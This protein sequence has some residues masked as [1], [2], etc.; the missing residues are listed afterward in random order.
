[1]ISISHTWNDCYLSH[2]YAHAH[3]QGSLS[4]LTN[5][6]GDFKLANV[7]EVTKTGWEEF[8]ILRRGADLP[9]L[10]VRSLCLIYK[11]LFCLLPEC[12]TLSF[13]LS[14]SIYPSIYLFIDLSISLTLTP[15]LTLLL[16]IPPSLALSLFHLNHISS[17]TGL[18]IILSLILSLVPFFL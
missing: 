7:T 13:P 2:R 8:S 15:F 1:M 3:T 5:F 12:L 4:L 6:V 9:A 10:R 14:F 17:W 18:V 16:C 11:G